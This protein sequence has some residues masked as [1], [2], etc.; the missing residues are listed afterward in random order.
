M[1]KIN[2]KMALIIVLALAVLIVGIILV[3]LTLRGGSYNECPAT[4]SYCP[5]P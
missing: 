2:R 1:L 3:Q 5:L 4:A